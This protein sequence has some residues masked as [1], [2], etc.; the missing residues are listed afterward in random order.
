MTQ[1]RGNEAFFFVCTH[2]CHS[3]LQNC[4]LL[5]ELIYQNADSTPKDLRR[6]Q[7][8]KKHWKRCNDCKR[9]IAKTQVQYFPSTLQHFLELVKV[10]HIILR[11]RTVLATPSTSYHILKHFFLTY[12]ANVKKDVL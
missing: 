5:E 9:K 7:A 12:F 3:A 8:L 2:F 6:F 11:F 1:K 10:E 4:Y